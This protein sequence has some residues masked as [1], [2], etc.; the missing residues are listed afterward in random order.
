MASIVM[1]RQDLP[2]GEVLCSYCTA[3]CCR[4]FALAID[5][6]TTWRDFDNIRW[7]MFHGRVSLFV[8]KKVWYLVVHEACKHLQPDNRCG[9]YATRPR[10]CR[11]Y[12]T[13]GC[14]Y[15]NEFVYDQLFETPEQLWEYAEAVLPPPRRRKVKGELA[16]TLP[17]L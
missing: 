7:F 9:T 14:E 5:T 17:V 2:P 16:V 15:D 11:D 4:Y 12:T 6:P 3:K 8:D 13:D 1:R 10:I